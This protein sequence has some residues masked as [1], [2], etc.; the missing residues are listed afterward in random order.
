MPS[1]RA[2]SLRADSSASAA[3]PDSAETLRSPPAM[4][5]KRAMA[6]SSGCTIDLRSRHATTVLNARPSTS[7]PTDSVNRLR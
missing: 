1:M 5:A 7:T 2:V 3:Q 4:F 6:R